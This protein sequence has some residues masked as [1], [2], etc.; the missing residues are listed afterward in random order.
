MLF[1]AAFV[2]PVVLALASATGESIPIA[3][4]LPQDAPLRAEWNDAAG[5]LDAW[6]A[7]PTWST[8]ERS[9]AYAERMKRKDMRD[10]R[11]GIA[12]VAGLLKAPA[13]QAFAQALGREVAAAALPRDGTDEPAV[14]LA[15]RAASPALAETLAQAIETLAAFTP[16]D[17]AA[18]E[19]D[20]GDGVRSTNGREFHAV[21]GDAVLVANDRALLVE[22]IARLRGAQSG[23]P[24]APGLH[25]H[26]NVVAL[27]TAGLWKPAPTSY[28]NA[29]GALLAYGIGNAL[30]HAEALDLEL[31]HGQRSLRLRVVATPFSVDDAAAWFFPSRAQSVPIALPQDTIA[32]LALTRDYPR[33]YSMRNELLDADL[34]GSIVEFDSI[35]GILFGGRSFGDEVLPAF[36]DNATLIVGPQDYA[37]LGTPPGVQYPGFTL[38]LQ[39]SEDG[40]DLLKARDLLTAFQTT[41]GVVNADRGQKGLESMLQNSERVDGIDVV[42]ARFLLDEDETGAPDVRFNAEPALAVT[43]THVFVSSARSHLLALLAAQRT[44][45]SA[46]P[47]AEPHSQVRVEFPALVSLLGANE[48]ALVA[49]RM[50]EHAEDAETARA[51]IQLFL[52]LLRGLD[53]LDVAIDPAQE[54]VSLTAELRTLGAL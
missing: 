24:R 33:F 8:I 5:A 23:A 35:M 7:S 34:K 4:A 38:V 15:T 37:D 21:V 40:K 18:Q 11:G 32:N 52:D 2:R 22:S 28:D 9:S 29:V 27:R 26:A 54:G 49:N 53:A 10:L 47:V 48:E 31:A 14:I 20:D 46:Q 12:I 36:G 19:D 25:M 13:Q 17:A 1:V 16:G 41:L 42:S 39:R 50:V 3:A 6:L 30:E 45:T 43:P 51:A 44:A